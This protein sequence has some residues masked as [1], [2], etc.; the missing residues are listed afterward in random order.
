MSSERQRKYNN[1]EDLDE[2]CRRFLMANNADPG[3]AIEYCKSFL[4]L[5]NE[6]KARSGSV[7]SSR[8]KSH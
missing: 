3:A 5:L 1:P 2:L 8:V 6:K 4:M 7:L